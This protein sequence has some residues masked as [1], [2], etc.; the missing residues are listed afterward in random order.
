ML[1]LGTV[2]D[3]HM[4]DPLKKKSR[5]IYQLQTKPLTMTES[6]FNKSLMVSHSRVLSDRLTQCC[7][8]F[9]KCISSPVT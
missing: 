5:Q 4:G 2:A 9:S 7:P 8:N 6:P 3:L 1:K